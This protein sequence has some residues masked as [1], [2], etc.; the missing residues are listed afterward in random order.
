M[1]VDTSS[2]DI[3]CLQITIRIDGD[4]VETLELSICHIPKQSEIFYKKVLGACL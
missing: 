4:S 2:F 1:Q 3:H